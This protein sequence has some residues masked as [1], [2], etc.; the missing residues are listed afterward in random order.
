M[1]TTVDRFWDKVHKSADCWLWT[2]SKRHKGY[3]A[4]VWSENGEV[5]QGRAHRYSWII[6]Q[7]KIPEGICVLHKCDT[8]PCVNPD[9]LF[10]GT[11]ADNNRDMRLK[12]RKVSGGTYGPG[13]Y[14]K[15][16]QHHAAKLTEKI[17]VEIR[18]KRAEGL[19]YSALARAFKI[20][21]SNAYRVATGLYWKDV[22]N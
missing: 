5:V 8:P 22:K 12:G 15:G 20:S 19:S 1:K 21:L 13:K 14:P 3:G 11:K 6:H 10:L 7:G 16:E 4:F 2:G 9:H 18:R 17:V